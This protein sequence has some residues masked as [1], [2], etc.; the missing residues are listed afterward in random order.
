MLTYAENCHTGS[1]LHARDSFGIFWKKFNCVRIIPYSNNFVIAP[2][3]AVD[4]WC[5]SSVAPLNRKLHALEWHPSCIIP[6]RL[7]VAQIGKCDPGALGGFVGFRRYHSGFRSILCSRDRRLQILS[8]VVANLNQ[9]VRS[10]PQSAGEHGNE[11]R[12]DQRKEAV[13]P[14]DQRQ[15][16]HVFNIEQ[17]GEWEMGVLAVAIGYYCVYALSEAWGYF[18]FKKKKNRID[19]NKP[20]N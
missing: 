1:D 16:A 7:G 18:V 4:S 12:A 2:R 9:S 3:L 14:I 20:R 8:L 11:D 15:R 5:S 17:A 6:I 10:F 19:Q 13:V